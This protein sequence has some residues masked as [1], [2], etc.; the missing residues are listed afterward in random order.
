MKLKWLIEKSGSEKVAN[1]ISRGTCMFGTIDTWLI[2]NLTGGAS[3]VTDVT[4]A[5]RTMLM[6]LNTCEWDDSLFEVLGLPKPGK[7]ILFP[8]IKSCAEDFGSINMPL[9]RI[10]RLIGEQPHPF[11]ANGIHIT[12]VVGDQQG[13]TI[14]Q[15]C[16]RIG[17]AFVHSFFDP[18]FF[19]NLT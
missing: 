13:A 15:K 11:S 10:A 19:Y 8:E 3:H 2:W 7:G 18:L 4:N 9:E 14:G 5:S 17:E 16:F 1:A 6:N 12:G